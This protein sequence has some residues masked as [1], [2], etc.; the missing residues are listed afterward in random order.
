MKVLIVGASGMIGREC[1][2]QCLALPAISCVVAFVR[3]PL[4]VDVSAHP[5]LQSVI[6]SDFSAWPQDVLAA[7]TDAVGMIW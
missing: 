5:K 6:I 7:Q 2:A 4:P 1:L 3:R